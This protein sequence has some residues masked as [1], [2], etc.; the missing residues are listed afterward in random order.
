VVALLNVPLEQL[1][2]LFRFDLLS[3]QLEEG[4]D[5]GAEQVR[6]VLVVQ[7]HLGHNVEE[8][9]LNQEQD[10]LPFF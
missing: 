2:K 5:A 6:L 4:Q 9:P 8:V 7:V 10:A 3:N 1:V